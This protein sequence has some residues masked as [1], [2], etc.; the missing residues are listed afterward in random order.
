MVAEAAASIPLKTAHE[1]AG[2][3]LRQPGPEMAPA[4]FLEAAFSELL[5]S[6]NAFVEAVRLPGEAKEATLFPLRS[7][8]VRPAAD[9]RGWLEAWAIRGRT[10]QERMVR[11][12]A[13][14][15]MPMLQVK[16]FHPAD[17]LMGL[18]PLAAARLVLGL[19]NASAD[20]AKFLINNAAKPSGALVYGGGAQMP[21]DQFDRLKEEL[22]AS[23]SGAAN[24]GRLLLLEGG[25]EW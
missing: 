15:W 10:G 18:S 20:W 19:D 5:L 14:S 17:D 1:G 23:F 3:L 13:Q 2:G 11:R 21:P 9:A 4:G 8:A 24:A 16:L 25:L 12:D 7:G 6:G 22:E